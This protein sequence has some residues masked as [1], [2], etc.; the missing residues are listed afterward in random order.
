MKKLR[1]NLK[2][3]VIIASVIAMVR[4]VANA[5]SDTTKKSCVDFITNVDLYSR[6]LWR[7]AQYGNGPAIQPTLKMTCKNFTL[8]A[9]G[10]LQA[11]GQFPET[12][13]FV[14]YTLPKGFTLTV[15]DYFVSVAE[16][17]TG[18]YFEYDENLTSHVLEGAL[19][20]TGPEKFPISVSVG[21]NFYAITGAKDAIYS[22]ISYPIKNLT[23]YVGAGNK[24]FYAG[25]EDFAVIS[26]GVKITKS[27]EITDKFSLPVTGQI[28]INPNTKNIYYAVGFSF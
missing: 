2:A 4:P 8:G 27:I 26:T 17:T 24:P 12:D 15:N 23:L 7:G 25:K 28:M 6:Y 20:Y 16:P 11:D 18:N 13:L 9:W 10:S 19:A 14:S 1:T 22:E 21:Y 5:Q 3:I